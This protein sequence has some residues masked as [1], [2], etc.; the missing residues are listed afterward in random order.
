[1]A[2][3]EQLLLPYNNGCLASLPSE[4]P[5]CLAPAHT[6]E[7]AMTITTETTSNQTDPTVLTDA[8]LDHVG[9]GGFNEVYNRGSVISSGIQEIPPNPIRGEYARFVVATI[10]PNPVIVT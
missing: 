6:C 7:E 2:S 9:G 1:M 8:E 3:L 5:A 10:P 4:D